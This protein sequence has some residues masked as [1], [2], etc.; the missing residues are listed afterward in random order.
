MA[1]DFIFPKEDLLSGPNATTGAELMA[2][3][4][5]NLAI[6]FC[7][8]V[9]TLLTHSLRVAVPN[10]NVQLDGVVLPFV[11]RSPVKAFM[12]AALR[13][14]VVFNQAEEEVV[15]MLRTRLV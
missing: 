11:Y 6:T 3:N 7:N 13:A 5:N 15:P 8:W 14:G 12:E 1:Q 4:L 10:C 2:Q 9:Y